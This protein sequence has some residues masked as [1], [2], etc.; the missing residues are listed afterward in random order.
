MTDLQ[1]WSR[2]VIATFAAWRITHLLTREDGPGDVIFRARVALDSALVGR[3]LNCFYCVSVW[4]AAPLALLVCTD[5]IDRLLTWIALAGAACLFERLTD[6][7][8][9]IRRAVAEELSRGRESANGATVRGGSYDAPD[10]LV[11]GV[12]RL[13]TASV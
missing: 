4:V 9:A 8:H 6:D 11:D 7:T 10:R 3:L 5:P 12:R 2:F 1:F 13:H